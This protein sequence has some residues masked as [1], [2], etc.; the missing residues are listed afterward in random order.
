[1]P[2]PSFLLAFLF[3]AAGDAAVTLAGAAPDGAAAVAVAADGTCAWAP[4][5]PLTELEQIL[6]AFGGLRAELLADA[7]ARDARLREDFSSSNALLRA[8]LRAE[9]RADASVRDSLLRAEMRADINASNA[10]LRAELAAFKQGI[11]EQLR[12]VK[13]GVDELLD[14]APTETVMA[15]VASCTRMSTWHIEPSRCTAFAMSNGTFTRI[16]SAAHCFYSYTTKLGAENLTLYSLNGKAPMTSCS[17]ML[18]YTTPHDLAVITCPE[19]DGAVEAGLLA[20]KG[21]YLGRTVVV[22]G[23]APDAFTGTML[24]DHIPELPG[25]ALNIRLARIINVLGRSTVGTCETVQMGARSPWNILP[26]GYFDISVVPGMS[27]G[28]VVDLKCGVVGVLHGYG[29]EAAAFT[30]ASP[31]EEPNPFAS[32]DFS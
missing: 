24:P 29:C 6:G 31:T 16:L 14:V 32:A 13:Q 20:S 19:F 5:P 2:K 18:V 1:M 26:K 3:L 21:S 8:E 28:P 9:M 22:A 12:D 25:T 15:K 7:G 17:V 4:P 27:G 23:F 10:L 30:S 11:D